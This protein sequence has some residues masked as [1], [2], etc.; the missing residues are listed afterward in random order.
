MLSNTGNSVESSDGRIWILMAAFLWSLSGIWAKSLPDD[1]TTIA[2]WRGLFAGMVLMP[3]T[4]GRWPGRLQSRHFFVAA[5]F[6]AMTG[7]YIAAIKATTAANAIFLQCSATAWVVPIGWLWLHE[8]PDRRT[9]A[10]VGLAMLG[11]ACIILPELAGSGSGHGLGMLLGV[12]SGVAYGTVVVGLRASRGDD[13][14]WLSAWNNTAGGLIL[15]MVAAA[16]GLTVWPFRG[17]VPGLAVF[18]LLQ[19][20]LPYVFF[21]RGLRTTSPA[22]A[23]LIALVE[24]LLN[25][26]WV[27]LFHGEKP[28]TATIIGGLIMLSGVALANI[29]PARPPVESAPE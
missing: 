22:N 23:T 26:V 14:L 7:M 17:S 12:A 24:P 28:H 1:G 19:M 2:I 11:I 6:A 9:L 5:A 25:P 16:C 21:S 3:F 18:G 29:R 20:A 8:K 10:G 27:W 4:K 15:A 13:P